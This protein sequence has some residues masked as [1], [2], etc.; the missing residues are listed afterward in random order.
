MSTSIQQRELLGHPLG[1]Y[2]CFFTEM[3]ERFSFYGMKALL[4]LYLTKYH[5][6]GD[7]PSYDLL[8]AYGGLVYATPVIGGMLADRYLGMR[9]AVILGGVLLVLGHIGMAFEGAPATRVGAEVVRDTGALQVFYFSLALIITGVGFLKPNISTIVGKLYPDNDPR[10]DSGFT[11]FYAGINLGALFASLICAYLGETF[12]WS[13]GFGAAGI[14]MLAGLVV[15]ISGQKHLQGHAEPNNPA[16]LRE[17]VLGLLSREH[18]IYLGS[19]IGVAVIW[20]LIQN[21]WTVHG[22]MHFV[23]AIFVIW[24]V[25]FLANRCTKVQREQMLALVFLI[26]FCL[27]FFTLYEQTYGSWVAFTDRLLT[28]DLF[29]TPVVTERPIF[30]WSV[31]PLALLPFAAAIAL[32]LADKGHK[33]GAGILAVAGVVLVACL[34]RDIAVVPQTAG[35]LTFLG[36]FFIVLLSPIFTWLWPFLE[37]RGMNPS[38]PAKSALGLLF[39]GLAFIPLA[40]AAT[41]TTDGV[42][43]SVWWLVLA[44]FV[45]EIGEMCL[46]PIGLS[47]V[48]QLSVKSVV[49]LMMGTWFLATAYSEVLAAAF[50]KLAAI[51]IP[52]GGAINFAEAS[53]KYAD[54]FWLMAMIGVGSAVFALLITPLLK[55][56]MHGVK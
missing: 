25:W 24:F 35:S 36:A 1:L 16:L 13:Y 54:L 49:S 32:N 2:V 29:G 38:K 46:S 19:L 34:L 9:K 48:T 47:A 3:W 17:K 39:G 53:A 18:A 55:R 22:V 7:S 5:L 26:F 28:K 23:A 31:V 33:S 44:Y 27:L 21:T 52:E 6:F 15:F 10:R 14:G 30:P 51:D 37:R 45:L 20:Q 12:G 42:M 11:L 50:G 4:F 56:W 43:A 40:Y 8:G 41:T